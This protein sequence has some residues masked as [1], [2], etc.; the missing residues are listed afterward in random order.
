M[1]VVFHHNEPLSRSR[2]VFDHYKQSKTHY[3]LCKRSTR[4]F[5]TIP[6][7]MD[8]FEKLFLEVL[9]LNPHK[10]KY[11]NMALIEKSSVKVRKNEVLQNNS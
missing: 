5:A 2:H 9:S 10:R 6:V 1:V 11:H 3:L 8:Q 7:Y 4:L